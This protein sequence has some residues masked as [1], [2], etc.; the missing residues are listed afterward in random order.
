ML[1]FGLLDVFFS[2]IWFFLFVMW[3]VLVIRVFGDIFR[4][5]DMGGLVKVIWMLFVM[6]VPL[7]GVFMY[8]ILRGRK[9]TANDVKAAQA[10]QE[11]FNTYVRQAAGS[12]AGVADELAK[13]AGLRDNGT[14]SADDFA[15]AKAKLLA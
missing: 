1:A 3:I 7:L 8:I 15:A 5:D 12:P 11:A 4:S 6:A 9:M 2:M 14:I 10:Q 13:L